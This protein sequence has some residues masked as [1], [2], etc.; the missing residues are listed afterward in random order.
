MTAP[1]S[2]TITV[3][4]VMNAAT[5]ALGE[6][7]K[8]DVALKGFV[9][10][11]A[12]NFVAM[13]HS[14]RIAT[15]GQA[16]RRRQYYVLRSLDARYCCLLLGWPKDEAPR[17][18][19][20]L[21]AL[22][23]ELNARRDCG[24]AV[25][26]YWKKKKIGGRWI[27]IFGPKRRALQRLAKEVLDATVRVSPYDYCRRRR[28]ANRALLAMKSAAVTK[29][30]RWFS[31]S[32]IRDCYGSF[33][34]EKMIPLIPLPRAVIENSILIPEGAKVLLQKAFEQQAS[35][36]AVRRGIPQGSLASPA[37]AAFLLRPVLDKLSGKVV[38]CHGDDI[39]TGTK[40]EK[41]CKS[42]ELALA[43]A[44]LE[45]PA[46]PLLMKSNRVARLGTPI[47]FLG[48]RM[49]R[50][51]KQFGGGIRFRPSPAGFE[52]FYERV[53][54]QL[55]KECRW[56]DDLEAVAMAKV[57]NWKSG[58]P[59]WDTSPT[60]DLIVW[61]ELMN[62]RIPYV[63]TKLMKAAGVGIYAKSQASK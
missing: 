26:A 52:K 42:N 22:A 3:G 40:T 13:L 44:C 37:V 46:G 20:E 31:T 17:S 53:M 4:D 11:S 12:K 38:L 56:D 14:L 59:L 57:A 24:E 16:K 7:W 49:V 39:V 48:Y 19:G 55:L 32:D 54:R 15:P 43:Q 34:R 51:R 28:G 1:T 58:L 47:D 8:S 9:K 36:Q 29:G 23:R 62:Q 25:R 63:R 5:C 27:S 30:A 2:Q 6:G 18:Q 60:G 35:E 41:E 61:I 21:L 50:R 33:D 45:H 10:A